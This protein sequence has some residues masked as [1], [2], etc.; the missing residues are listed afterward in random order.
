M[1]DNVL[2]KKKKR[3]KTYM[4]KGELGV[5]INGDTRTYTQV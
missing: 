2:E 3:I 5:S 1:Y 4:F